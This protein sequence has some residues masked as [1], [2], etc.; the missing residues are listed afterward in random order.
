MLW[1]IL[2]SHMFRLRILFSALNNFICSE[3]VLKREKDT[4]IC[5]QELRSHNGIYDSLVAVDEFIKD[6]VQLAKSN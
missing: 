3:F 1:W 4:L 5:T 6:R 2:R